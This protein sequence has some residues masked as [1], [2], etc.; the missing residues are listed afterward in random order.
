MSRCTAPCCRYTVSNTRP[1]QLYV[2]LKHE[3]DKLI[4]FERGNTLWLFN[5]H[6][7]KSFSDYRVPAQQMGK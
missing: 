2:S 6:P 1:Q 7:S 4:V 5:F 3:D